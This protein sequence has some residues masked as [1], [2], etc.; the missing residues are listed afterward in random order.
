MKDAQTALQTLMAEQQQ[1]E[2]AV[3]QAKATH[4]VAIE[5]L[6]KETEA[7]R[8]KRP[9]P[10]PMLKKT[11]AQAA[12][13]DFTESDVELKEAQDTHKGQQEKV[14]AANKDAEAATRD[15]EVKE[16]RPRRAVRVA[17]LGLR[18]QRCEW[19][20]V[21]PPPRSAEWQPQDR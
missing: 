20:H 8:R 21:W 16:P 6:Q 12:D 4:D 1:A 5:K 11:E 2:A 7:L 19:D 10:K 13:T 17:A 3:E 14:E 9:P 15:A 18:G